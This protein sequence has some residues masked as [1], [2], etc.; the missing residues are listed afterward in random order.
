MAIKSLAGLST[1]F[2]TNFLY[3][4][5]VQGRRVFVPGVTRPDP[6]P[7]GPEHDAGRQGEQ[8]NTR[9]DVMKFHGADSVIG[10]VLDIPTIAVLPISEKVA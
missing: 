7:E 5:I 2:S 1:L 9:Q 6:G 10:S 4:L 3:S 8:R